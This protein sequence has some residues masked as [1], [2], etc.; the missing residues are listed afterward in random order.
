[1]K[2][3]EINETYQEF[4]VKCGERAERLAWAFIIMLAGCLISGHAFQTFAVC[5]ML[6]VISLLLGV[7]QSLWQTVTIW[8]FKQRVH[9]EQERYKDQPDVT[10]IEPDNYP[11]YVGFGAWVFYLLK[12]ATIAAAVCYFVHQILA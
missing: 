6:S 12:I 9:R 11:D 5:A 7:L 10:I 2:E 1:M 8:L 4:S 3:S